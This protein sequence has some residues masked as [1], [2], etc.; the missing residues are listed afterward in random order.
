MNQ[1]FHCCFAIHK[2]TKCRLDIILQP[3]AYVVST[4]SKLETGEEELPMDLDCSLVV[5]LQ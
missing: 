1:L 2:G 4:S 5:Y 3:K